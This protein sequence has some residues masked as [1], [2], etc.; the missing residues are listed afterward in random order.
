MGALQRLKIGLRLADARAMPGGDGDWVR[1][2][3]LCRCGRVFV[4]EEH[5][6]E[7]KTDFVNLFYELVYS[8]AKSFPKCD[9]GRV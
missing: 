5:D 3:V 4:G 9:A 1:V 6:A 2:G 7:S 8:E